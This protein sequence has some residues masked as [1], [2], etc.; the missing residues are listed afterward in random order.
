MEKGD[1]YLSGRFVVISSQLMDQVTELS[2][3][4]G[5]GEYPWNLNIVLLLCFIAM[6]ELV[7]ILW[8][9]FVSSC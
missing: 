2:W 3:V 9:N 8:E 7:L 1:R 5:H 4:I 6:V